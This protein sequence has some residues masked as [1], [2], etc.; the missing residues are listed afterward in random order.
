MSDKQ[1]E[2]FFD[3]MDNIINMPGMSANEKA[4]EI[5][6]RTEE[7]DVNIS[8]FAASLADIE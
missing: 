1:W 7:H 3:L 4:A 6:R 2:Q 8:E 5:L